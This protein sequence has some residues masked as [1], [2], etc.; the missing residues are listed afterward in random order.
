MKS[1]STSY[2][3]SS[4]PVDY[5]EDESY[6]LQPPS[7]VAFSVDHLRLIAPFPRAFRVFLRQY[8]QYAKKVMSKALQL[9][10]VDAKTTEPVRLVGLSY[11]VDTEWLESSI[12]LDYIPGVKSIQELTDG[13]LHAY[14]K[15]E[16]E[17]DKDMMTI[18]KIESII[19]REVSMGMSDT[20]SRSR[21]KHL[22]TDYVSALGRNGFILVM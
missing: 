10:A 7:S 6:I 2:A 3:S 21:M 18:A 16:A 11:C 19:R 22:F 12:N 17:E 4:T 15:A 14:L 13:K 8:D 5:K 20:S 9:T 1:S